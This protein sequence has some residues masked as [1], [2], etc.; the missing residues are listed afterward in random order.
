MLRPD[1]HPEISGA[2][3]QKPAEAHCLLGAETAGICPPAEHIRESLH[4]GIQKGRCFVYFSN[5]IL[6][7]PAEEPVAV[8]VGDS[9]QK[10]C[11]EFG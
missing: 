8:S 6:C 5:F 11:C 1:I 2:A 4:A 3:L 7:D 9:V 10:A